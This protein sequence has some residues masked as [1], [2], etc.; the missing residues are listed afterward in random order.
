M[1][2]P[3]LRTRTYRTVLMHHKNMFDVHWDYS[4]IARLDIFPPILVKNLDLRE[5]E[6]LEKIL[7]THEID[8]GF[9]F[10]GNLRFWHL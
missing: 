5:I 7:I 9:F 1:G 10:L 4:S 2:T 6:L 8:V 3:R